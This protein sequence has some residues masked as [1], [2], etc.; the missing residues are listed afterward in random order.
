MTAPARLS[1]AVSGASGYIGRA[2]CAALLADGGFRVRRLM[3]QPPPGRTEVYEDVRIGDIG[4]S[5]DWPSALRGIDAVVHLA[6]PSDAHGTGDPLARYR[7][8]NV[9]GTRRLAYAAASAGV[10]R[11]IFLS[12]AKVHGEQSLGHPISEADPPRPADAYAISKAEAESVLRDIGRATGL[13]VVT[14]RPP[15]VYGPGAKGNILR[16]LQLI[17]RVPLPLASIVNRRSLIYMDNLVDAIIASLRAAAPASAT[18]LVSDGE[19]ISTPDLI[20]AL[21]DGI[22]APAR[23]LPCPIALLKLAGS[24][25]GRREDVRRLTDSLQVDISKIRSELCWTPPCTL[26]AGLAATARWYHQQFAINSDT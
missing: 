2:L 14:L 21:A 24:L 16:L 9:E 25:T 10:R 26:A 18:Y 12:S 1:V 23:L 6:S 3:R 19:D 7:E 17:S 15:A 8:V 11:F 20:R 4:G 5:V 22:G 13:S